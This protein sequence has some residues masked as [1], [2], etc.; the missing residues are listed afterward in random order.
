MKTI[1][2]L[3]YE[4]AGTTW[5][6][7]ALNTPEIWSI[8]EVFSRNPS[9]YYWNFMSML[10]M[11]ECIPKPMVDTFQKIFHPQNIFVDALSFTKIKQNMIRSQPFSIDLLKSFQEEAYKREKMLCF[12]IFPYHLDQ[13]IKIE[14]IIQ[15]SDYVI[16][17]YRNNILETFLSWKLAIKTGAWTS[18]DKQDRFA[19]P[20]V[21]WQEKEYT[22][23]YERIVGYIEFWKISSKNKP[24]AVIEY[25]DIHKEGLSDEQK[26]LYVKERLKEINLDIDISLT[27]EMQKQR[28]YSDLTKVISNFDDF[29]NSQTKGMP[30]FY[31]S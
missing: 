24:T 4:R 19:V 22:D 26:S 6:S 15:L 18:L 11:T 28:D 31:R 27:N 21:A 16:I 29:S 23:F 10:K 25:E 8:F 3:S 14:E 12:K 20:N 17:N 9:L 1:C 2:I 5:L 30:I 13:N 7:T